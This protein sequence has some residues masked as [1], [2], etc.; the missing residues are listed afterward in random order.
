MRRSV[1]RGASGST[2]VLASLLLV[3]LGL[4]AGIWFLRY[5][6][7]S[8]AGYDEGYALG[9]QAGSGGGY[10]VRDPTYAEAMDFIEMDDT[11]SLGYRDDF[12]C[13]RFAA[14]FKQNAF[15]E[16]I[17]CYYVNVYF[18]GSTGHS[19][20]AFDTVDRGLIFIEPQH[21]Q[22]VNLVKGSSYCELNDLQGVNDDVIIDYVLIP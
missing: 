16:G 15:E 12:D 7:G 21:D 3:S 5:S 8:A 11:D 20:V 18:K 17:R 2:V 6:Q 19:I 22:E 1:S 13:T 9:F 4:N 14:A 10:N